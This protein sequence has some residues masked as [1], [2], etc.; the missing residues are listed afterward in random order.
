V[1]RIKAEGS[2]VAIVTTLRNITRDRPETEKVKG[3]GNTK[4]TIL[5]NDKHNLSLYAVKS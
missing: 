3:E 4:S 2:C 5:H 1:Y